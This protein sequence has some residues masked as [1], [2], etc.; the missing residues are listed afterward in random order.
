MTFIVVIKEVWD[1]PVEVEAS[2]KKEAKRK[3][4]E[5]EGMPLE[6]KSI[7]H[8]LSPKSWEVYPEEEWE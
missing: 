8:V 4:L 5:G 7:S 1:Q 6:N 3:V 2:S